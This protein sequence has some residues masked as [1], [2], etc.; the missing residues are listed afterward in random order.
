MPF[1]PFF[2]IVTRAVAMDRSML[3]LGFPVARRIE[4]VHVPEVR[5]ASHS[6][7]LVYDPMGII[8]PFIEGHR[9]SDGY[10]FFDWVNPEGTAFNF[11]DPVLLPNTGL[12]SYLHMLCQELVDEEVLPGR[13]D[14]LT[15]LLVSF[16]VSLIGSPQ[17]VHFP[18][19]SFPLAVSLVEELMVHLDND[20]A[21][22]VRALEQMAGGGGRASA[23]H[24]L[25]RISSC[26]CRFVPLRPGPA[27]SRRGTGARSVLARPGAC[28]YIGKPRALGASSKRSGPYPRPSLGLVRGG[29]SPGPRPDV[30]SG[31][32]RASPSCGRREGLE[33]ADR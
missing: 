25:G 31:P 13:T 11:L 6:N 28:P 26:P 16:L 5:S 10:A 29:L 32:L 18:P 33:G 27:S 24:G 30:S 19:V 12:S 3:V 8:H 15:C 20:D 1:T 9:R 14:E 23:V 17:E 21:R 4:Q 2:E 22:L 7:L